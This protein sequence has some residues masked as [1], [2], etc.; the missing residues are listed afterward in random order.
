MKAGLVLR[1]SGGDLVL[2]AAL[3]GSSQDLEKSPVSPVR[4]P[5]VS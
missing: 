3:I 4:V 2:N 5:A 1:D